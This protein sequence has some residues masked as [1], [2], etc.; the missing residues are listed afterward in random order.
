MNIGKLMPELNEIETQLNRILREARIGQ[1]EKD[2]DY[3]HELATDLNR[4]LIRFQNGITDVFLR[5]QR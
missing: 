5:P 2:R 3:L 4:E 1:S